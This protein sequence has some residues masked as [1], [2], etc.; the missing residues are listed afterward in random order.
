V[1]DELEALLLHEGD[2]LARRAVDPGERELVLVD[3]GT[4]PL[5]QDEAI[6]SFGSTSA[7]MP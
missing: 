7:V 3:D 1:F 5:T 6:V 4:D 2:R